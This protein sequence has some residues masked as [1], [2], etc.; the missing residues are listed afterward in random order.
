MTLPSP[1]TIY[2]IHS[3]TAYNIT[4]RLPLGTAKVAGGAE[5]SL[6]GE[7]NPLNGGSSKYPWKVERGLISAEVTLTLR[8]YPDFLFETLLGKAVTTNSAEASGNAST[9]TNQNGTSLVDATT[10]VASVGVKSGSEADLKFSEYVVKAVTATTV[11]VYAYSDV[12]FANGTDKTFEDGLLKITASPLSI[13]TSTAVEVPG[14]GVELTG[15]SG[16]IGMT[17]DDTAVFSVRPA[18][19]ESRSVVIGSTNEV[20][21]DFGLY[22]AAQRPG[23]K[24]MFVIDCFKCAGAGL[25]IN[26]TENEFSEAS[27]TVQ[28][29]QDTA[30]NGIMEMKSVVANT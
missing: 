12:D 10:G 5:F 28:L 21:N 22:I 16:T 8:E 20:F 14:F 15:G 29:Y 27:V 18:N 9:L 17:V 2:G 13:T 24:E 3:L 26:F 19:S 4:T 30:R 6:E 7:L 23:D 1:K 11:D 25:P